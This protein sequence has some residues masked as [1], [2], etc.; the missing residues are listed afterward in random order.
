M[1]IPKK[2]FPITGIFNQDYSSVPAAIY[3][4]HEGVDYGCI[5]GSELITTR[6][7]KIISTINGTTG[8]GKCIVLQDQED[9]SIFYLGAHLSEILVKQGDEVIENDIIALSGNTGGRTGVIAPHLHSGVYIVESQAVW[10]NIGTGF[11][12]SSKYFVNQKYACNPFDHS[13]YWKGA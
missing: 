3:H 5:I 10:N 6:N 11:Y 8:Y 13:V 9:K 2:N 1:I 7:C 4:Y 12:Y